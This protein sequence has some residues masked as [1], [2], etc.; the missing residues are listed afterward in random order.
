[1]DSQGLPSNG[2]PQR[3]KLVKKHPASPSPALDCG[4]DARSVESRHS[5][6]SLWPP[7]RWRSSF[8]NASNSS[9]PPCAQ[10]P[11]NASPVSPQAA[12]HAAAFSVGTPSIANNSN[13]ALANSPSLGSHLHLRRLS[14]E[15]TEDLLGA[16]FDG[17]AIS[18]IE[19][20]GLASPRASLQRPAVPPTPKH[21]PDLQLASPP[22]RSTSTLRSMDTSDS[23]KVQVAR[24][25]EPQITSPKR[26]SD[27]AKD[28]KPS[29]LRKKSGLSAI[30]NSLVGSQ[31][32]PVISAPENPV[33]V[34][35]V[36]YDSS[37]GQFT[38]RR[39]PPPARPFP[40]LVGSSGR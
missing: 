14:L 30:V 19:S 10:W 11:S 16:P 21:A 2:P 1:M 23:E 40:S 12:D 8:S 9:S 39:N 34:T 25:P 29:I 18:Q 26:F 13:S 24:V 31:K 38:V 7:P 15:A 6:Q 37:T 27:E 28:P 3:R 4:F 33:H 5:A 32:K 17:A 35:H 22:P 36:G 20:S